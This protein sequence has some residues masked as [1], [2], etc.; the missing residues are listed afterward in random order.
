MHGFY[1]FYKTIFVFKFDS[2]L[3]IP[4]WFCFYIW[5]I[6]N[7]DSALKLLSLFNITST[8]ED[9]NALTKMPLLPMR[10]R[11]REREREKMFGGGG[12]RGQL[13]I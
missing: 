9:N 13:G 1:Y 3:L 11:G 12:G 4:L 6:L 7:V 2:K 5:F 10:V 8:Y